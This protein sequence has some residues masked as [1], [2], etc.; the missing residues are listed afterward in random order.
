MSNLLLGIM[1]VLI[2]VIVDAFA[3]ARKAVGAALVMALFDLAYSLY[4]SGTIDEITWLSFALV[5]VLG[6]ISIK[7]NNPLFFKLQPAILGCFIA[8]TFLFFYFILDKPLMNVFYH[9]Y[10]EKILVVPPG[11]DMAV[12]ENIMRLISRDL[13]WW[14]LIHALALAYAAF[15]MSKWWWFAIR[16]PIFYLWLFIAMFVETLLAKT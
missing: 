5:A 3:S 13:A 9:K 4:L 12:F 8:L 2:F 15:K 7:K 1:P 10:F 14:L 6:F 16:V 11:V